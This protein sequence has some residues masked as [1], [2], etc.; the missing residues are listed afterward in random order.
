[1]TPGGFDPPGP[2]KPHGWGPAAPRAPGPRSGDRLY[3]HSG[4]N[5]PGLLEQAGGV[6]TPGDRIERARRLEHEGPSTIWPGR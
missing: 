3:I 4:Q 6:H 1:M 5:R 2:R